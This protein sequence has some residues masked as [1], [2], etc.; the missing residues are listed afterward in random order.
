MKRILGYVLTIIGPLAGFLLS[1]YTSPE[2]GVS[3]GTALS[4][5]GGRV[6]HLEDSPAGK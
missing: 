5:V 3:V 4:G 6:L 2:V 1:K